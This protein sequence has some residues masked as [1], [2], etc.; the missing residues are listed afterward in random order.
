MRCEADI[1]CS[2]I[3]VIILHVT[4]CLLRCCIYA[5][6]FKTHITTKTGTSDQLTTNIQILY[7]SVCSL[8]LFED[9]PSLFWSK[10]QTVPLFGLSLPTSA[11]LSYRA[12]CWCEHWEQLVGVQCF[13][14][15]HSDRWT[16]LSALWLLGHLPPERQL[17]L[18]ISFLW[19]AFKMKMAVADSTQDTLT[20][21]RSL[22]SCFIGMMVSE[23]DI[24]KAPKYY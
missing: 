10:D 20:Q 8:E 22:Q 18:L 9:T 21:F 6:Y 5:S 14:Q 12:W 23:K 11:E 2:G 19:L 1:W 13:V 17:L 16:S 3:K 7:V 24:L 15:G 4:K